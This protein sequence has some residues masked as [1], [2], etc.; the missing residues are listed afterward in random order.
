MYPHTEE[1]VTPFFTRVFFCLQVANIYVTV[2]SGS[3]VSALEQILS[4]PY[5]VSSYGRTTSL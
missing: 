4:D 1:N 2:A 5:A 3:I